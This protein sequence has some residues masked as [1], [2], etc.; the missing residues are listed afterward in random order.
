MIERSGLS[1]SDS[2]QSSI[3]LVLSLAFWVFMDHLL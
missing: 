3:A 2:S 1:K